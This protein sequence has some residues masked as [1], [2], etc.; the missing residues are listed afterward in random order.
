MNLPKGVQRRSG[1]CGA[2]GAC[3]FYWRSLLKTS[4][5]NSMHRMHRMHPPLL[6]TSGHPL[7]RDFLRTVCKDCQKAN[8]KM[9]SKMCQMANSLALWP[10]PPTGCE[11]HTFDDWGPEAV[12]W[13]P[14]ERRWKPCVFD[15]GA[16]AQAGRG[17]R[18]NAKEEAPGGGEC[19]WMDGGHHRCRGDV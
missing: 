11:W 17:R 18:E 10:P 3:Y 6:I 14:G 2:C 7:F 8:T 19:V 5:G 4:N 13:G 16:S 15:G 1:A 9:R 12:R